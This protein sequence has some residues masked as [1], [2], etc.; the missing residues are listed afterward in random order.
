MKVVLAEKPSVARDIAKYL[1]A[2]RRKEGYLEGD[3]WI[4]TWSFGHMVELKQPDEYDPSYKR[5]SLETLPIVPE[6][7]QLRPRKDASSHKQLDT[8]KQLFERAD[9]L[10]CAT[11]AGREG[12]LIFRYIL[13]WSQCMHKPFKRL[14]I[15]SL[16][17]DAI[18]AGFEKL[19]DG[20]RFDNL[21]YAAK[22]RSESDWIVGLNATRFFTVKHGGQNLWSV[23]RVQTPLLAM[24]VRRDL[25]I[26]RFKPEDYWELHT[27]YRD[28]R[29]KHTKG[30]FSKKEEAEAVFGK[31]KG[32]HLTLEDIQEKKE[33]VHPPLLYDLTN[34][35][36]DLNKRYGLTADQTL[37]A[38]QSLYEKKHITYPRTDSRFLSADLKTEI[39]KTLNALKAVKKD[40]IARLDPRKLSFTKRIVND[41]KV[42][43]H[44]AIIPTHVI[45]TSLQGDEAKV[46][47]AVATRL[48][49]AFYPPCKK[50][51]TT[52]RAHAN[53]EP[54]QAKGTVILDPGWQVLYPHMQRRDDKKKGKEGE[55][56]DEQ[57]QVMPAFERGESGPHAPEIKALKTSPPKC[58]TEA[59]LL[60]M[61]ETAGRMVDDE[62]LRDALKDKGIGTPATRAAIIEVLLHRKYIERK[63][64]NL[65]ST[66]AGRHLI[67]LVQDERLKSP[68]LTGEWEANLKKMEQGKYNPQK[69]ISEVVHYTHDILKQAGTAPLDA[70]GLGH[71]PLCR[72]PILK[73]K[74]G[75]GCSRWKEGCKFVLWKKTYNTQLPPGK[76]RELLTSGT[77]ASPLLLSVDGKKVLANL[78]IDDQGEV[79]WE[80][81]DAVAQHTSVVEGIGTCPLC[82]SVV[83]E[84]PK[85][86]GCSN[87]RSGCTFVIWKSIAKKKIST[88]MAKTLLEK[89]ETKV[90]KGFKSKAGKTFDAKLKLVNS[91]VKFDF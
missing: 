6:T 41:A 62:E 22:C 76:A 83:A 32:H 15:S 67:S 38:A 56:E 48:I 84:S 54:F 12:E 63:K 73:G 85:A 53:R 68:E 61:M 55:A 14:W 16:T 40:A 65:M 1:K 74:K 50:S 72:A 13:S 91:E 89:G 90:L 7:F 64:K 52:V 81:A 46:Y 51:V 29:F 49:A 37:T 17:P 66:S 30:K 58:F 39:P 71:C 87:W 86:Y 57:K 36:K 59:T 28:T 3:G 78:K 35:Q 10:V 88:A 23:G 24:I 21:Y 69:F 5:W 43:D 82:H 45:A 19:A 75:Y 79:R 60:H 44:H 77:T 70:G 80:K 20:H 8:I 33:N 11:D 4:V 31:V 18:K 47:D 42:S 2:N 27:V 26:E 34:L 9:E 25:D